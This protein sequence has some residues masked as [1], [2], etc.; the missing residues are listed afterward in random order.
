MSSLISFKKIHLSI[1]NHLYVAPERG[2]G[3]LHHLLVHGR[4]LLLDGSDQRVL[5]VV[6]TSIGPSFKIAAD[7]KVHWIKIWAARRPHL[8][9]NHVEIVLLQPLE[10]STRHAGWRD[11]LPDQKTNCYDLLQPHWSMKW[12]PSPSHPIKSPC[13]PKIKSQKCPWR[14]S[15]W[16]CSQ[17]PCSWPFLWK[18]P[19]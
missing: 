17:S 11:L 8:L 4:H 3:P 9:P 13:W 6:S 7:K 16:P 19:A 5:Y 15:P 10:R 18:N 14:S 2:T 1:N 12:P